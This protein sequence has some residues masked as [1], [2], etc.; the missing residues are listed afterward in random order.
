[1]AVI[2]LDL[3]GTKL[4][5]GI[6]TEHAEIVYK[7]ERKLEHRQGHE[8]GRLIQEFVSDMLRQAKGLGQVI[9]AVGIC[10]PGI[11]Y[12]DRGT[13]WCPNIPGWEDYPLREEIQQVCDRNTI[14]TVDSDRV[15]CILGEAWAGAAENVNNAI[16]LA[17]GT[18][19][20]AGILANGRVL[21]GAHDISGAIGWWALDKEYKQKYEV[22]GCFEHHCSGEGLAKIARELLEENPQYQG[23]LRN[24]KP[25]EITSYDLFEVYPQGDE[26]A[27]KTF[28]IAIEM[29][30]MA[31]ANLVSLFD[32][33]KII[34]GGGVFG[35]ALQFLDRIKQ[36]AV[37]HAQPIAIQKVEIVPSMLGGDAVLMGA[38]Y[39]ALRSISE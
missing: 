17:V 24:R 25:E 33:S 30:G 22:C 9:D 18:G 27:T 36:A 5:G 16:F 15:C 6:F 38:G 11:S 35:P 34:F 12:Q 28:D 37:R 4:K 8:V 29:W 26:I 23:V 39:L 32:P 1:M 14:V 31:V 20:A 3:G 2:G 7:D 21:R 10:V 13:V 19:I